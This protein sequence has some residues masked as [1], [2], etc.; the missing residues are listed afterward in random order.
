MFSRSSIKRHALAAFGLLD[1]HSW[2]FIPVVRQ[3][4]SLCAY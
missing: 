2:A 1:G 3:P 4:I